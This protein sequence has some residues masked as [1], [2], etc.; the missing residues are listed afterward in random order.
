MELNR[1]ETPDCKSEPLSTLPRPRCKR[2]VDLLLQDLEPCVLDLCL[3]GLAP[4][5]SSG[6]DTPGEKQSGASNFDLGRGSLKC[7][8]SLGGL[9]SPGRG[10]R[11][12]LVG[13][14][15]QS[16]LCRDLMP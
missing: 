13:G 3:E 15:Q 1:P 5:P 4:A 11:L 10:E 8:F 6:V 12:K 14:I 2:G 7:G 16:C 9:T